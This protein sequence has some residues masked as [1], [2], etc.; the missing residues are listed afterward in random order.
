MS[1]D[2]STSSRNGALFAPLAVPFALWLGRSQ[3]ELSLEAK[4][5]PDFDARQYLHQ[6]IWQSEGSAPQFI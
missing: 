1:A 4:R 5:F 2:S 6:S 3:M